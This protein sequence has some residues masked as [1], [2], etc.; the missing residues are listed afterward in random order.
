MSPSHRWARRSSRERRLCYARQT[1]WSTRRMSAAG[2]HGPA[3]AW[4]SPPLGPICCPGVAA[5]TAL[6]SDL[7]LYLREEQTARV[8]EMLSR[9]RVDGGRFALP[10]RRSRND[11]PRR[12]PA[13]GRLSEEPRLRHRQHRRRRANGRDFDAVGRWPLPA[14]SRSYR[15][16]APAR[17]TERGTPGHRAPWCRWSATALA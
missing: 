16:P 12:G 2:R 9:G 7:R 1:N 8:L 15:L 11:A 14:Q 3:P 17:P 13:A 5:T 6:L 10:H 4:R